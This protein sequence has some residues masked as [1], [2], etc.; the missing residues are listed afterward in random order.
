MPNRSRTA[1][2]KEWTPKN[3]DVTG[4]HL[5]GSNIQR[6]P[7]IL[8]VN[9]FRPDPEV[10]PRQST[11]KPWA[12]A[13]VEELKWWIP[14]PSRS[15]YARICLTGA[16]ILTITFSTLHY[17][18]IIISLQ[19]WSRGKCG[20]RNEPPE[21]SGGTNT[22]KPISS[23]SSYQSTPST[24]LR[25]PSN[26]DGKPIFFSQSVTRK[27]P[28][29]T[30]RELEC[31]LEELCFGTVKKVVYTREVL[32]SNGMMVEEQKKLRIRVKP[33]WKKGTKVT[34]EGIG[35]E[36]PGFL[37][38]DIIFTISEKHHYLFKRH[39]N[40]LT[41]V[42]EIPLV[43]ALTG[44]KIS[45]PL[46]GGSRMRCLIDEIIY[47]GYEMFIEG[48]G[49][50]ILEEDGKRGNLQI[51]FYLIFPTHLTNDQRSSI[52]ILLQDVY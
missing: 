45:I 51:K 49:M 11:T 7:Q 19:L 24:P 10:L 17:Q 28:P 47:P 23:S 50:P 43:K 9:A 33:G 46:L 32:D 31:T 21:G 30:Q 13:I 25:N 5:A 18:P 34:F 36:R 39:G 3:Q 27:Q 2:L 37:P 4:Y 26:R 14:V 48:Q 12:D 29:P 15:F 35:D 6:Q 8:L 41:L 40:D 16:S 42:V 22:G 20:E 52:R 44:C 1:R 38:A